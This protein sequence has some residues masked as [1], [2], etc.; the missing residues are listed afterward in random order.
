[1][2]NYKNFINN[3]MIEA[4][5]PSVA[6]GTLSTTLHAPTAPPPSSPTP[7]NNTPTPKQVRLKDTIADFLKKV[8]NKQLQQKQEI[9]S[10]TLRTKNYADR[11]GVTVKMAPNIELSAIVLSDFTTPKVSGTTQQ[12]KK[13]FKL[14][15]SN[16]EEISILFG[17]DQ[18]QQTSIIDP[19]S[20]KPMKTEKKPVYFQTYA[21]KTNKKLT[22][23]YFYNNT[24]FVKNSKVKP[25]FFKTYTIT[26]IS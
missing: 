24:E 8:K 14:I 13:Y 7:T 22:N 11:Q 19:V 23:F 9:D 18:Q 25:V 12:S 20:N 1:M 4:N 5:N 2:L 6:S 26:S 21:N 17:N 16:I 15:K 10:L 3:K